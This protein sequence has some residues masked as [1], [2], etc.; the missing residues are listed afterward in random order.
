[1]KRMILVAACMVVVVGSA[2][3][4][5][6]VSRGETDGE[7]PEQGVWGEPVGGLSCSIRADKAAYAPGEDILLDV[8]LRNENMVPLKVI[9]PVIHFSYSGD[10]LPLQV[11]GPGGLC[12][13]NGPFLEPPPP[14]GANA[15]IDL[16][17]REIIGAS[18]TY[19]G[20]IRIV[21]KC[22]SMVPGE[23]TIRLKFER[24]DND[25]SEGGQ[26]MPIAGAW[27]GEAMSNAI[28]VRIE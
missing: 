17:A 27:T 24:K 16:P 13:Y 12:F 10:A 21:Q 4:L 25:Y 11:T 18:S 5:S 22:W 28:K 3:V 23:Y 20:P 2:V 8:F 14:P 19:G 7:Q 26:K 1:M 6:V 9:R 15:W